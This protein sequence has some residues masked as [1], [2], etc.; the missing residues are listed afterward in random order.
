MIIKAFAKTAQTKDRREQAGIGAEKQMAFYLNQSFGE[1]HEVLVLHGLRLEDLNQPE[2]NGSTGS[3]QIDH[4][5]VHRW[6]FFIIE[7][8]SVVEEVRV[9]DDGSGG[10]EWARR[11]DGKELGMPSPIQQAQRQSDFLRKF[12]QR[13]RE[14]LLGRQSF[15]FRTMAKVVN[16]TDQ[17]G[18]KNA[19][20][21][22]M[23]AV[24]DRGKIKRIGGWKEPSEPFQVYVAK[25]DLVT[26]KIAQELERHRNGAKSDSRRKHGDYGVWS[27]KAIEV[28]PVAEFLAAQHVDRSAAA[29]VRPNRAAPIRH[30]R[31]P[32]SGD[33]RT[34]Q[35]ARASCKYC[36]SVA[37]TAQSG[38]YGP[39]WRCRKCEKNTAMPRKCSKCGADKRRG[40]RVLIRKDENAYWRDCKV[41]GTSEAIWTEV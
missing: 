33:I 11:Y 19:P 20:I 1:D 41:C 37:L 25:A 18:F 36:G 13:H 39:Y 12:L 28:A 7:S 5:L 35:P 30:R 14:N 10:D 21:Q 26:G 29:I 6:G 32:R 27:M 3:C 23:I 17:R 16:G 8:K 2:H 38:R 4:L 9:R 22:L 34:G 24:S 40:N 15:G 31:K